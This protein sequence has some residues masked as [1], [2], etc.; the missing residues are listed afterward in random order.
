[1]Y[2]D[3]IWINVE[4]ICSTIFSKK[5][6]NSWKNSKR[7]EEQLERNDRDQFIDSEFCR[8]SG[9]REFEE[10][11]PSNIGMPRG[12]RWGRKCSAGERNEIVNPLWPPPHAAAEHQWKLSTSSTMAY[13]LLFQAP[14]PLLLTNPR[15]PGTSNGAP[16]PCLRNDEEEIGK[17]E[18]RRDRKN[19]EDN[20]F[21]NSPMIFKIMKQPFS[22]WIVPDLK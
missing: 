3:S 1:M 7:Y 4:F 8:T 22:R 14:R 11:T 16:V 13:H 15:S 5:S 21:E 19:E 20:R 2:Y 12:K 18:K 6:T 9:P 17:I 10:D